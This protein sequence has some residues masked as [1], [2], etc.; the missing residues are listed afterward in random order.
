MSTIERKDL[1]RAVLASRDELD[2]ELETH[3]LESIVDAEANAAG[4]GDAALRA[5]EAVVSAAVQRG[6]GNV[7]LSRDVLSDTE[8]TEPEDESDADA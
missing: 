4:D 2:S 3:L 1:V 8:A 6:V 7:D 5:V